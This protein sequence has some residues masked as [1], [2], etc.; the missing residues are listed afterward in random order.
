MAKNKTLI[1][2]LL[3]I[4]IFSFA[5]QAKAQVKKIGK[6]TWSTLNLNVSTFKNGDVLKE[7][8]SAAEWVKA[9]DNDIPAWCYYGYDPAN[10]K[11]YGKIYNFYAVND[12]RGL[13]PK[14]W[15]I[16]SNDEWTILT[17]FLGGKEVAGK[18]MKNTKGWKEVAGKNGNGSNTSGFLGLPGGFCETTGVVEGIGLH[19]SWWCTREPIG[20]LYASDRRL[21][22]DRDDVYP[23]GD[24]GKAGFYVR[25][26]MD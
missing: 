3:A 11:K 25:C 18:K 1:T 23:L 4:L 21:S 14:G 22:S 8:K 19:C 10:G 24:F 12:K 7:I 6:Q 17:D 16:P 2:L 15:H 9:S 13:A 20:R 26:V 5:N